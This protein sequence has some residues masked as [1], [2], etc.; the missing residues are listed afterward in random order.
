MIW[1]KV[2]KPPY[3]PA[4]TAVSS[5]ATVTLLSPVVVVIAVPPAMSRFSVS[6]AI[7][8]V[9][10]LSAS[11]FKVVETPAHCVP[12]PVENS[13]CPLLPDSPELSK[14]APVTLILLLKDQP[15]CVLL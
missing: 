8:S 2:L 5:N 4:V 10:P 9:S 6:M 13:A 7:A 14:K 3:V 1:G 11:T 12:V 15:S